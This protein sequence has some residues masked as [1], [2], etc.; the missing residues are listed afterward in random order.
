[1]TRSTPESI[2]IIGMSCRFPAGANNPEKYWQLL[3]DGR[4]G[5]S[6]VPADRWNEDAFYH[7]DPSM[8]GATNHRGG[9]FIDQ[10]IGAFDPVFFGI[11]G[12]EAKSMDP[13][14]RLQ[15]EI[16][17]ES[18]ENAGLSLESLQGSATAVYTALFS[19]DYDRLLFKDMESTTKYHMIGTGDAILSNRISHVFD[20]RGPSMT[21]DTGCSGSL[22]AMHQACQSLRTGESNL[23]LV[24]AS[25]L[26]LSPDQLIPMSLS[27]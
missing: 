1:M 5:W 15:L 4:D 8:N 16:A 9:Y 10:D 11:S 27:Q 21:I 12:E 26:I 22:V 3:S 2:A 6:K 13:Q 18:L 24:G 19:R 25:N 23:A 14:Q 7:P 20:F 17:Y